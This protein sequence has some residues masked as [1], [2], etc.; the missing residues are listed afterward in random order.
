[1][2]AH[3]WTLS[4]HKVKLLGFFR[5]QGQGYGPGLAN[6]K[7][8][9]LRSSGISQLP[10]GRRQLD[11][12]VG[13]R[14]VDKSSKGNPPAIVG[15]G[16]GVLI[17]GYVRPALQKVLSISSSI[18]RGAVRAKPVMINLNGAARMCKQHCEELAFRYS[19]DNTFFRDTEFDID[20]GLVEGTKT[21]STTSYSMLKRLPSF[22][23]WRSPEFETFVL[24]RF[25]RAKPCRW[26]A[27][28]ATTS[29]APALLDRLNVSR[30]EKVGIYG[31]LFHRDGEWAPAIV[32]DYMYMT[33]AD[34]DEL[35]YEELTKV[36][37]NLGAHLGDKEFSK[38]G[39]L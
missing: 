36:Y 17:S 16:K 29:N 23:R 19:R 34:W 35:S 11:E 9:R 13:Q 24:V 1:M 25:S 8:A 4:S 6:P 33:S 7:L 5:I 32:D 22:V 39:I 27:G 37:L 21:A 2:G 31:F 20:V 15:T 3:M 26:Q 30:D 12:A 10:M 18:P 38:G 14:Q 28:I